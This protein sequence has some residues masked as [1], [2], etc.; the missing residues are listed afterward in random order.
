M[1]SQTNQQAL[2]SDL[3]QA[4]VDVIRVGLKGDAAGVRQLARRLIRKTPADASAES[5]LRQAIGEVLIAV[6]A[7]SGAAFRTSATTLPTDAE[8]QLP[9]VEVLLV[10]DVRPPVLSQTVAQGVQE[11]LEERRQFELLVAEGLRPTSAVLLSGPPGVGKTLTARYIASELRLPLVTMDLASLMS[12]FLGRTGQNLKAALS[13]AKEQPC[14]VLLDEFDALAK[15]RDDDA[16][17]GELKRLVNVLL[18]E[19]DRWPDGVLL[20]AATNH[21][22]L[23]DRAVNRR[24]DRI[25]SLEPPSE[26]DRL[27]ILSGMLRDVSEP[28]F[29]EILRHCA[30]LTEGLTGSDLERLANAASRRSL[31]QSTPVAVS[32]VETMSTECSENLTSAG[33]RDVYCGLLSDVLGHS[34]RQIAA[35][36]GITHPTVG[37]AVDRWRRAQ[38][39]RS[40][41]DG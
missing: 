23:L 37:K 18:L 29:T 2:A 32:L 21:P 20:I 24:F 17:I 39:E 28:G 35:R 6:P 10:E 26:Q 5:G 40:R 12:S 31:I 9:L 27:Q 3:E 8:T 1:A 34:D 15:R 14:V 11:V 25:L 36:L 4:L 7:L 41:R 30:V 22:E 13:F 33:A 38:G 16:D 19:L